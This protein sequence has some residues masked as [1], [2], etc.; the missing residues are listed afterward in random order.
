[1]EERQ[2]PDSSL[3]RRQGVKSVKIDTSA[4]ETGRPPLAGLRKNSGDWGTIS[5]LRFEIARLKPEAG[6]GR[7]YRG[8]PGIDRGCRTADET[9]SFS[10][11]FRCDQGMTDSWRLSARRWPR[12]SS[13]VRRIVSSLTWYKETRR[14]T[15]ATTKKRDDRGDVYCHGVSRTVPTD[16]DRTPIRYFRIP[17][18]SVYLYDK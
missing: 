13:D 18:R 5:N 3:R 11:D 1:M 6:H 2:D 8:S 14:L 15:R 9:S 16:V 10:R 4:F 12:S 17:F 7:V